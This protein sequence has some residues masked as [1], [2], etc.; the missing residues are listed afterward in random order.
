MSKPQIDRIEI[1]K[2]LFLTD[3]CAEIFLSGE[4][5]PVARIDNLKVTHKSTLA[6]RMAGVNEL[7]ARPTLQHLMNHPRAIV[8]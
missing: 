1:H 4:S 5:K 7:L 2:H 3:F 8:K 6:S